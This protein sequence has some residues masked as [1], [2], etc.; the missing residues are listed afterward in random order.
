M[1]QRHLEGCASDEWAETVRGRI[2]P[3]VLEDAVLGDDVIEIGPGPGRTTDILCTLA[4]HVT[5][6]ELDEDL[7]AKLA[8]RF[9]GSNVD[10]IQADATAIPREDNRFSAAL[11]FTM[12]H[13]V[14]TAEL[15][16]RIFAELVRVLRPGGI[17]AG[18]DSLDRPEFRELHDDDICN[19]LDPETLAARLTVAG[20]ENVR[21]DTSKTRVRF[22]ASKPRS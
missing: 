8:A 9:E 17:F 14:P 1:N 20:F 22:R 4:E 12:M 3:W 16:D 11:A 5:A 13:H 18:V 10:V 6:V 21:V 2:I 7:A 19:P 15:Q